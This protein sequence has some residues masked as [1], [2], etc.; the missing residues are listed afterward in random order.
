[1]KKFGIVLATAAMCAALTAPVMAEGLYIGGSVGKAKISGPDVNEFKDWYSGDGTSVSTDERAFKGFVGYELNDNFAIEA[2]AAQLGQVDGSWSGTGDCGTGCSWSD[3]E[4]DAMKVHTL[5]VALR[6]SMP[7]TNSIDA[8][9]KI[10]VH[11]WR[12]S[13]KG[14]WEGELVDS[15]ETLT[16][17]DSWSESG[18]DNAVM[19]GLGVEYEVTGNIS[20]LLE[21][22]RYKLD[23]NK[24]TVASLGLAY[25]F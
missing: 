4:R 3:S 5:G 18:S 1:M 10:G 7:I 2:F 9:G 22:E 19:F 24:S 6:A 17:S 14:S 20:M 25:K 11:H 8:Y 13:N 16:A 23:K 12:G 21:A 15:G